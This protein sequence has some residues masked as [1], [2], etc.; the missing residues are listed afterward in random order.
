[1]DYKIHSD[2]DEILQKL[3]KKD[4]LLTL[5][6]LDK[7]TEIKN[8]QDMEHYKNLRSPLQIYK[9]VHISQ[10]YVLIFKYLKAEKL[11]LFRCFEHRDNV[12]KIKFD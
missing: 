12:C 2:L 7:I 6:I 8:S 5:R 1:M 4:K 9:R 11:V 10:K 3:S